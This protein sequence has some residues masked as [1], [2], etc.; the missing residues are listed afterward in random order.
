VRDFLEGE[1][2]NGVDDNRNGLIDE[3]G[4]T[5]VIESGVVRVLLTLERE[6]RGGESLTYTRESVVHC[7][8]S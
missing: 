6:G 7:R 5:F 2:P 4:L 1:L 8:N 3:S